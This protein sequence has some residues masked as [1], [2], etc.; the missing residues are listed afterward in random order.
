MIFFQYGGGQLSS[1]V[2]AD[3]I[4]LAAPGTVGNLSDYVSTEYIFD[5]IKYN[6]LQDMTNYRINSKIAK[7]LKVENSESKIQVRKQNGRIAYT[8]EEDLALMDFVNEHFTCY[9]IGGNALYKKAENEKVTTH[10]W[11]SMRDHFLKVLHPKTKGNKQYSEL[12]LWTR[13]GKSSSGN[14]GN[15]NKNHDR[16]KENRKKPYITKKR[17][18][19]ITRA[20]A[21][22]TKEEN[23]KVEG[24]G[25][26]DE[27]TE[28]GDGKTDESGEGTDETEDETVEKKDKTDDA[29]NEDADDTDDEAKNAVTAENMPD[30]NSTAEVSSAGEDVDY[31]KQFDDSLLQIAYESK[32]RPCVYNVWESSEDGNKAEEKEL[33]SSQDAD[34]SVVTRRNK[35]LS[36]E[37]DK[38]NDFDGE[39]I[40]RKSPSVRKGPSDDDNEKRPLAKRSK[41]A[42]EFSPDH[43]NDP[44]GKETRE[45]EAHLHFYQQLRSNIEKMQ[46]KKLT[47]PQIIHTLLVSSGDLGHA[48]NYLKDGKEQWTS[49]EDK[50]LLSKDKT[51]ITS[52]AKKRGLKAVMDRINFIEGTN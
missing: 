45:M 7:K 25:K 13:G 46:S 22:K 27:E 29:P 4:K 32:Q 31:D 40:F 35:K 49:Q 23:K 42:M 39:V 28:K 37:Q 8:P 26:E 41:T 3:S 34:S 10:T 38:M 43:E 16:W 2:S 21:A 9:P 47:V 15:K 11:Q 24:T 17:D 1:K 19:R 36:D 30:V 5:S 48:E 50:I 20:Q 6:K 51:G 14:K 18:A 52:L 44:R 12:S 33:S